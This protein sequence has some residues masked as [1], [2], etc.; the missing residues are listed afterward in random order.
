MNKKEKDFVIDPI[1][2]EK[3]KEQIQNTKFRATYWQY[4]DKY[5]FGRVSDEKV[6]EIVEKAKKRIK[7]GE[8]WEKVIE[9]SFDECVTELNRMS[10]FFCLRFIGQKPGDEEKLPCPLIELEISLLRGDKV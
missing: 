9:E 4:V 7:S 6:N 5:G 1:E 2:F 8:N 3:I 10:C